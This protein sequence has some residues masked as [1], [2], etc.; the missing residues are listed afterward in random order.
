MSPG[1]TLTETLACDKYLPHRM[2]RESSTWAER[3]GCVWTPLEAWHLQQALAHK[4][5]HR[6]TDEGTNPMWFRLCV[7]VEQTVT[8]PEELLFYPLIRPSHSPVVGG[9]FSHFIGQRGSDCV[10]G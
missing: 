2:E 4:G 10:G 5:A 3:P 7:R 1:E 8:V 9:G 6:H